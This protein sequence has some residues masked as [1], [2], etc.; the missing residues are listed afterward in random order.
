[1]QSDRN[2]F[3]ELKYRYTYGGMHVKLIFVNAIVFL[4]IAVLLVFAR[5]MGQSSE[6]GWLSFFLRQIFT[7]QADFW[8]LLTKPWGLFTSMFAHF[9]FI[10]FI[11]NMI[12][13]YF[14]G[15]ILEN[16]G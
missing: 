11:F 4:F 13:L 15:K 5:L 14:S 10:H 1:M 2:F 16:D 3:E 9:G 6:M 8:G 12:F 7:L